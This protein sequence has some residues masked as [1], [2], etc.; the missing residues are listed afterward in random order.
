M[1]IG[2]CEGLGMSWEAEYGYAQAGKGWRYDLHLRPTEPRRRRK[3][4]WTG[5]A[6]LLRR[7]NTTPNV[8][9]NEVTTAY[10]S[11]RPV[12]LTTNS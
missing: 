11:P 1:T 10:G 3:L 5:T 4:C 6:A 7:S 9:N 2:K 8:K 12:D